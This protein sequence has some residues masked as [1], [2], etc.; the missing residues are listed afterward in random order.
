MAKTKKS[1]IGKLKPKYNFMMNP[2]PEMRISSCPLCER[3]TGQRKLPLLIHIDPLDFLALNYTC[4]Y[5]KDC[6]LLI[7]HKH[8]I[9]HILTAMLLDID[10][11]AIGNRYLIIGT[12]EKE[13]WRE[14]SKQGLSMEEMLT[15][16]SD[17]ANYHNELR[18]TQPGWYLNGI[19]P[20]VME[21][22]ESQ[23]WIKS[24]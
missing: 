6:D 17:F 13:V 18:L 11:K 21:P 2:Y 8:E 10:P 15:H 23:E 1:Q 16:A 4:K 3:K 5:C 9:E 14:G 22:P 24:K 20:P 7:A 19:E 12:I